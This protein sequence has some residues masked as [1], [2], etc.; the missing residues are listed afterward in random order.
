[1]ELVESMDADTLDTASFRPD[2]AD[3]TSTDSTE[4]LRAFGKSTGIV[5]TRN[6]ED[7]KG[8]REIDLQEMKSE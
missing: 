7:K 4:R 8:D 5:D 1:M 2:D 3:N 6:S